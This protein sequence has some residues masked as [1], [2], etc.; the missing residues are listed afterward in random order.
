MWTVLHWLEDMDLFVANEIR[1]LYADRDG[2]DIGPVERTFGRSRESCTHRFAWGY[3]LLVVNTNSWDRGQLQT[4]DS[5]GDDRDAL[6]WSTFCRSRRA[7]R[8]NFCQDPF[9]YAFFFGVSPRSHPCRRHC[10][11]QP[12]RSSCSLDPVFDP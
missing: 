5:A 4:Y 6:P 12:L 9:C 2:E 10:R 7:C 1:V 8:G 3:L 11:L